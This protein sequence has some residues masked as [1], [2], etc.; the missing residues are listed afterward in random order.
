VAIIS[1]IEDQEKTSIEFRANNLLRETKVLTIARLAKML[2]DLFG[3]DD[4]FLNRKVQTF[5]ESDRRNYKSRF[6][7]K[8]H[9]YL[10]EPCQMLRE[11]KNT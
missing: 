5:G 4:P 7:P 10:L 8:N 2:V 3:L 9:R 6:R 11:Q 1:Q